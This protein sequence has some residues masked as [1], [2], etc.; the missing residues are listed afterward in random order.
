MKLA[1]DTNVLLDVL[2][3]RAP[4]AEAAGRLWKAV[5]TRKV[6]GVLTS[7]ALTTVWYL[8]AAAKG[9]A[10]AR[11]L[12]GLLTTVFG[13]AAVDAAVVRRAL[14]LEFADFE[15]AVCAAAA[16]AAGC[17]LVVT[18]NR[19]DFGQSPVTAVDPVTALALVEGGAGPHGVSERGAPYGRRRARSV[20]PGRGGGATGG[21]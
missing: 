9:P 3:G 17:E 2:L 1:V 10:T 16:E 5:E 4:F 13:V 6:E 11:T 14:G 19:K 7:H 15:D 12:V 20:R 18:R 8:V 21:R